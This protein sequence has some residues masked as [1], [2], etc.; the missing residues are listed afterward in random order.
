METS[1]ILPIFITLIMMIGTMYYLIKGLLESIND[2]RYLTIT[3]VILYIG[4]IIIITVSLG[5]LLYG[6]WI[7]QLNKPL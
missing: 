2:P 7:G 3:R 5:I 4:A 6:I 1:L